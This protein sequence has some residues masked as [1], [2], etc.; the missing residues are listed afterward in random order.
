M[1]ITDLRSQIEIHYYV[2]TE[3]LESSCS[4]PKRK[5]RFEREKN[6]C[7][8]IFN[9]K[10]G[11]KMSNLQLKTLRSFVVLKV[12]NLILMTDDKTPAWVAKKLAKR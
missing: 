4:I 7:P 5:L 12:G 8:F 3:V 9:S 2:L 11:K 1:I 6:K 10:K